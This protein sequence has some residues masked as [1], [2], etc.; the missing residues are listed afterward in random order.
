MS[1]PTPNKPKD[2]PLP[3]AENIGNKIN[4]AKDF[5]ADV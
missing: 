5:A 1:E 4:K 2:Q 3:A